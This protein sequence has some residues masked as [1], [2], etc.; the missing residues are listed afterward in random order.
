[1]VVAAVHMA[2]MPM[3]A[4]MMVEGL[5]REI[6]D[7]P[8]TKKTESK[9][10]TNAKKLVE[11]GFAFA[12][13]SETFWLE[14][15]YSPA[16]PMMATL[17]PKTAALETPSVDG[18]AMSLPRQVWRINPAR[19]SPAPEASAANTL[20]SL[21]RCAI[22]TADAVPFPNRAKKDSPI[23]IPELP[24]VSPK[25]RNVKRRTERRMKRSVRFSTSFLL[26]PRMISPSMDE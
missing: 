2:P 18:E 24:T 17:A 11:N 14:D 15:R 7:R 25:K 20:G 10:K 21:I 3:P 23:D 12:M 6:R 19:E 5:K 13:K 26:F 16:K 1:M 9:A 8:K 22:L 4:K